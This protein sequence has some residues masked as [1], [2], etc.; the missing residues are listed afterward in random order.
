MSD[1]VA[2]ALIAAIGGIAAN[3]VLT[4]RM[5][6]VGKEAKTVAED[7]VKAAAN[8]A[9]ETLRARLDIQVVHEAVNG[10]MAAAKK[11]I[12]ELKEEAI[13][14]NSVIAERVK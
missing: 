6:V 4:W 1:P 9:A 12:V 8:A 2:L 11:E 14:L 13:R 5:I 10:G 7:A 3:V